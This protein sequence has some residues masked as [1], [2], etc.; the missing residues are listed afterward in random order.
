MWKVALMDTPHLQFLVPLAEYIF[1]ARISSKPMYAVPN[2]NLHVC[3]GIPFHI[4]SWDCMVE[5]CMHAWTHHDVTFYYIYWLLSDRGGAWFIIVCV[6]GKK[7]NKLPCLFTD[8]EFG[9]QVKYSFETV[10]F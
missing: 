4:T 10:K 2:P 8:V 5:L 7:R 9:Y 3:G 1:F 6:E